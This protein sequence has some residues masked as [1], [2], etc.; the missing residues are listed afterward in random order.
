MIAPDRRELVHERLSRMRILRNVGDG[1]VGHNIGVHQAGKGHRYKQELANCGRAG[2]RHPGIV[3]TLGAD[4][5]HDTLNNR[6][7]Q[8]ENQCKMA[9]FGCHGVAAS[10]PPCHWPLAF[11]FSATSAGI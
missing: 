8:R 3:I 2:D 6:Q 5:G 4:Q 10:S 1:K 9:K 7:H 11:S